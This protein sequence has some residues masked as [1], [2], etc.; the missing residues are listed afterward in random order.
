[1]TIDPQP[2]LILPNHKQQVLEEQVRRLYANLRLSTACMVLG[3]LVVVSGL[4]DHVPQETL[5]AWFSAVVVLQ[6]SRLYLASR[7]RRARAPAE[8]AGHWAAYWTLGALASGIIW[9]SAS[10]F[11]WVPESIGYQAFVIVCLFAVTAGAFLLITAYAPAFYAFVIPTL[12]PLIVRLLFTGDELHFFIG[13]ACAIVLATLLGFGAG[14][15]R[16]LIKSLGTG[17]ENTGLIEELRHEKQV[18]DEARA[19][20]EAAVRAKSQFLRWASHDLRQPLH[21]LGLLAESVAQRVDQPE[22]TELVRRI[23][24][25]VS[26]MEGFFAELMDITKLDSGTIRPNVRAFPLQRVFDRVRGAFAPEAEASELR[27]V[28]ARTRAIVDS[29]PLLLERILRNLVSNA[30]RYTPQGGVVVGCRRRGSGYRIDV[31]DTGIGI[32]DDQ[33]DRVFEEFY[34][35]TN[36]ARTSTRGMGLGLA[37]VRRLAELLDHKVSVFS[38]PG[39]G[40]RFSIEV[41]AGVIIE[42]LEPA[43]PEML[44]SPGSLAGHHIV[45]IDDEAAIVHGM[46]DLLVGWGC[47]VVAAETLTQ[48][49]AILEHQR[50]IPDLLI[51]DYWMPEENGIKV[52]ENLRIRYGRDIP[53]VLVTGMPAPELATEARALDIH[54]LVKPV[55]PA[56]LRALVSF[57]L[58]QAGRA[59]A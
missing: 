12:L 21:A 41:P 46:R 2:S 11:L 58:T 15:N 50:W 56:R 24:E 29:D 6:G 42:S 53:A 59:A 33:I 18:S 44:V 40:T 38:L 10:Y 52:I 43:A 36:P 27:F 7:Y 47:E 22:V 34:Q 26:A 4:R 51:V 31:I 16:L 25:S 17:F 49:T 19:K 1:M 14:L 20:A 54:L 32:P 57:S 48:A 35:V 9:G 55:A 5:L 8:D 30:L 13:V 37:T 39:K 23:S 3:A 28:V 45:V